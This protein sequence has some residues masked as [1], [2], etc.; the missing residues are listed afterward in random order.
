MNASRFALTA[1][2]VSSLVSVMSGPPAL[3]AAGIQDTAINKTDNALSDRFMS[4]SGEA[5]KN[6]SLASTVASV[7]DFCDVSRMTRC[8][9]GLAGGLLF[10]TVTP[11]V[12]GPQTPASP[13]PK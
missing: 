9:I 7:P 2:C 12:A 3:R 11:T 10:L 13:A 1:G 4:T 8:L 5:H 6:V